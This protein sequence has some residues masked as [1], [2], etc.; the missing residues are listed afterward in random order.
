[1]SIILLDIGNVLFSVDFLR[2]CRGVVSDEASDLKKV[3]RKYCEGDLKTK[4]DQGIIAPLDYLCMIGRDSLTGK[5][6]HGEI[7][8]HWQSVFVP[9]KGAEESVEALSKEH[10]IW[11]MSDTDPIHF[12]FL[13]SRY[14]VLKNRDRYYLSYE[15]GYLKNM[16]EAFEHVIQ[17]SGL[18]ASE[19]VLIDDNPD[20][21]RS[22]SEA[23][24]KS[25]RF[26]TWPEIIT[27]IAALPNIV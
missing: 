18:A 10:Q 12:D 3:Y 1:M 5:M 26:E 2:F 27:S 19:F 22:A 11:I 21:C 15:H 7:R 17:D 4:L 6:S 16:P 20:N 24:I 14:N 9:L 23:G 13:L 8:E 25:I